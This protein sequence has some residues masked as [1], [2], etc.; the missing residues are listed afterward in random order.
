M[1]VDLRTY[2]AK[3]RL[4]IG[5]AGLET[6]G[7]ARV[8]QQEDRTSASYWR[9]NKSANTALFSRSEKERLYESCRTT[10]NI[11]LGLP[12]S[13]SQDSSVPSMGGLQTSLY[14]WYP[15]TTLD[16]VNACTI[17]VVHVMIE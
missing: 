1:C 9:G 13:V 5:A 4:P 8:A 14:L 11:S 12:N 16:I 10:A 17:F 15:L 7:F 2:Q 3:S 6:P